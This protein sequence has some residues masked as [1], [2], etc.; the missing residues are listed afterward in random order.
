MQ[1]FKLMEV[2]AM[3]HVVES[4]TIDLN[5]VNSQIWGFMFSD[6][7]GCCC[8]SSVFFAVLDRYFGV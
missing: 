4:E 2:C 5:K 3:Y 8:H 6:L 1:L 7:T